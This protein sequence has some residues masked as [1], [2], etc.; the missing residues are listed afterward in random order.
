MPDLDFLDDV[1]DTALVGGAILVG[2]LA[3]G[4]GLLFVGGPD[5]D[6]MEEEPEHGEF[7]FPDGVDE[8]GFY[9]GQNA[10]LNHGEILQSQSFTLEAD[11][12]SEFGDDPAQE[13]FFE[14]QYE[15][16]VQAGWATQGAESEEVSE[17]MQRYDDYETQ[18]Q[19]IA[20]AY[21]TDEE[22]Y[23]RIMLMQPPYTAD[24]E[25]GEFVVAADFEF[26]GIEEGPDG[27]DVAVFVIVGETDEFGEGVELDGEIHVT[28]E[29]Y[30]PY[31]EVEVTEDNANSSQVLTVSD[32]GDTTV[33]EP[34]WLD[35]AREQTDEV[36]MEDQFEDPEGDEGGDEEDSEE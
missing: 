35:D 11:V 31:L 33:E 15:P 13:S 20:E 4:I 14:Y 5:I 29:G 17:E 26:D 18:E 23:E 3:I 9:D 19:F 10:S 7:E 1:D 21:G 8:T 27:Q 28:E 24:M 12:S 30:F 32:V 36:D 16:E 34:D 6:I 25:M 2:V 22:S